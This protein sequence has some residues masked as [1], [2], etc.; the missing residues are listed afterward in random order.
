MYCPNDQYGLG[1]ACWC[2]LAR[3]TCQSDWSGVGSA[4]GVCKCGPQTDYIRNSY[5]P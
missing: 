4:V 2:M 1:A 3:V 5:F